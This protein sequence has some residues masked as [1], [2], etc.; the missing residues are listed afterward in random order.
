MRLAGFEVAAVAASTAE[1]ARKAARSMRVPQAFAG[2]REIVESP[3][4][5]AVV[6]AV[7]PA[8]QPEI[9]LAALARGKHV[10]CEKPLAPTL[11]MA[12][13]MLEAARRS[14]AAHMIDLEFPE[15]A[16]WRKARDVLAG[17]G[18]G[19][20]RHA[21]LTWHVET[22]ASR[23]K[24]ES[25]KTRSVQGGGVLNAFGS[26]MF[27]NVEWLLGPVRSLSAR[28]PKGEASAFL[29][30]E[31]AGGALVSAAASTDAVMGSGH[32]LEVYGDEGCLILENQGADYIDGFRLSRGRRGEQV[33]ETLVRPHARPGRDGRVAATAGLLKRF[34]AWIN[35]G[36]S[37]EPNFEQGLRVQRLIDA[38]R[39]SNAAG[40][41]FDVA[42][43]A[44]PA[45]SGRAS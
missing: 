8:A 21:A 15:G 40:V 20:L 18:I 38:A 27:H 41:S 19:S 44:S 10:F 6:I 11:E 22:R 23:L 45:S 4:I 9:A 5:E 7:P 33:L 25:W 2:W 43:A 13:L 14:G 29:L 34:A 28:F 35:G 3:E 42:P 1:R 30:L 37:A 16:A 31:L 36:S 24:L 12:G 17:G 26:H 39:R 32:R